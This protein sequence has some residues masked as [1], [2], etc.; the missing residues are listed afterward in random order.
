MIEYLIVSVDDSRKALKEKAMERLAEA[1]VPQM[2]IGRHHPFVDGRQ[3]GALED[4]I[5]Y[6][7]KWGLEIT[8]KNFH[9]GELGI[10][11]S[12]LNSLDLWEWNPAK[13]LIVLEDDASICTN[14]KSIKPYVLEQL[15]EDYDFF[16]WAVPANQRVDY[17]YDRVFDE[18]GNW[19]L[20]GRPYHK[21]GASPHNIGKSLVC[22]AYQGYHA[23]AVM[24]SHTG[25]EKILTLVKEQGLDTPYDLFLFRE[26]F[27]GNLNGY[28]FLPDVN[29][30]ITHQ[31]TGTIARNSGMFN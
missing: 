3:R 31:E 30:V 8:G 11:F 14:F 27:K 25:G 23:V 20:T 29:D 16:A 18:Q 12:Q 7:G 6:W 22:K 2:D 21:Y 10:W 26:H 1:G 9:N 4:E 5:E 24:Y 28:T 19:H 17:Y 15:P 13:H